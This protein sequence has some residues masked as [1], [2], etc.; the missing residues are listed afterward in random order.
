MKKYYRNI[1]AG[2]DIIATGDKKMDTLYCEEA[3]IRLIPTTAH[4]VYD[5]VVKGKLYV[6]DLVYAHKFDKH[7]RLR[8]VLKNL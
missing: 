4:P 8:E 1:Y 2:V 7:K 3:R 5:L 6:Q